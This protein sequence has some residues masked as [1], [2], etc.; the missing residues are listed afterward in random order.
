MS[1]MRAHHLTPLLATLLLSAASLSAQ[2]A[3]QPS[4]GCPSAPTLSCLS[5][6]RIGTSLQLSSM[7]CLGTT[8]RLWVLGLPL[9]TPIPLA[10][11]IACGNQTCNLG[12]SPVLLLTLPGST[13]PIPNDP[14]LVGGQVSLQESCVQLNNSCLILAG[15][16]IVT[17]MA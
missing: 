4:T 8:Y 17:I 12:S 15:A 10:P 13:L 3:S 14:A 9:T 5:S 7:I 1:S 11:P 6:P 16:A 2:C